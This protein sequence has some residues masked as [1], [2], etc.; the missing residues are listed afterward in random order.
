MSARQLLLTVQLLL[1]G[2]Q[3]EAGYNFSISASSTDPFQNSSS[4]TGTVRNL[5]L[6]MTCTD[7]AISAFEGDATGTLVVYGFT[8]LNGVM[9]IGGAEV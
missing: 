6:W 4:P 8:P 1:I 7:E 9:N 2:V 3:A 5:Y